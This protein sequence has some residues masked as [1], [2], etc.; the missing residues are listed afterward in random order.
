[1]GIDCKSGYQ[2]R[3]GSIFTY[4]YI[5]SRQIIMAFAGM[6]GMFAP[7]D[8]AASKAKSAAISQV[9]RWLEEMLPDEERLDTLPREGRR[10]CRDQ[11]HLQPASVPRGRLPGCGVG[12][13]LNQAKATPEVDVQDLQGGCRSHQGG[14]EDST[15]PSR[16]GGKPRRGGIVGRETAARTASQQALVTA[17][18]RLN[19]QFPAVA[20]ILFFY[21][22]YII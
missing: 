11:H 3:G 1:M 5:R 19:F 12:H 7:K 15:C 16:G 8:K 13:H 18:S 17:A 14:A 6:G 21:F 22:I 10:W 2:Q 4:I 20:C 9:C